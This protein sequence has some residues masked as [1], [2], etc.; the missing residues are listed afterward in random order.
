MKMGTLDTV[1]MVLVVVGALN[2]GLVGLLDMNLVESLLGGSGS[3]LVK[4]VYI[5][6][7]LSGVEVLWKWY[8]GKK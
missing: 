1:A 8:G 2:W 6:V 4:L 3:M 7:G 5:L